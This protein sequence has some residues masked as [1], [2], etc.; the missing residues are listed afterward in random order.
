MADVTTTLKLKFLALNNVKSSMF[1]D[2][3]DASTELANSL[4]KVPFAA[5]KKLT[6]AMV[7]TG[8]KSALSNQVIRILSGKAGKRVKSFKV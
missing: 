1:A 5:R 2:T 4:L 3:V 7:M 8:L 6:T